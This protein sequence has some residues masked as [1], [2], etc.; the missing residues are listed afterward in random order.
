M[1]FCG[2]NS[3]NQKGVALSAFAALRE[4]ISRWRRK[5]AKKNF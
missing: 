1:R 5:D 4:E 2:K 3:K